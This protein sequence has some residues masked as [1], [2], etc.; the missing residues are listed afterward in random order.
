MDT[1]AGGPAKASTASDAVERE[2]NLPLASVEDLRRPFPGRPSGEQTAAQAHADPK[3]QCNQ[4]VLAMVAPVCRMVRD[5]T[6][7]VHAE[8]RRRATPR[9]GRSRERRAGA[10]RTR[11]SRR[12]SGSS[13]PSGDDG[14]GE[15][16]PPPAG[17]P[18]HTLSTGARP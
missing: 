18:P 3:S 16:E 2:Q 14:P 8:R 6:V 5:A 9:L 13:P 1:R 7:A 10:T 15:S 12:R 4:H 17:R 11:G